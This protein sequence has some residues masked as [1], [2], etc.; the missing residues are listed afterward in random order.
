MQRPAPKFYPVLTLCSQLVLP[1]WAVL[2]SLTPCL[3]HRSAT[4]TSASCSLLACELDA[5][6]HSHVVNERKVRARLVRVAG[7]VRLVLL[8]ADRH[9]SARFMQACALI[10][11]CRYACYKSALAVVLDVDQTCQQ[12][13]ESLATSSR[14]S[15]IISTRSKSTRISWYYAAGA[16]MPGQGSKAAHRVD[17][18]FR[19]KFQI[20]SGF[21]LTLV[22]SL[23]L[24]WPSRAQ[25]GSVRVVFTKAG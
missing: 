2:A 20:V 5:L 8:G 17:R 22:V 19:S 10:P 21:L 23:P 15:A 3:R 16:T 14:F 25:M 1:S 18:R 11:I 9:G 7:T 6:R 12:Y 4:D 13:H 24:S